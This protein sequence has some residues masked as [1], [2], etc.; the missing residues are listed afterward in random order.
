MPPLVDALARRHATCTNVP[1]LLLN[2]DGRLGSAPATRRRGRTS[3]TCPMPAR[4]LI[5]HYADALLHQLPQA[6]GADGDGPRL[7]V[8]VQL[9]L[10]LEVSRE[11]R[12]ARSRRSAW[13]E[14][15][16]ADR[17]AERLHHRR[18]LLDER[19]ARRGDGQA[20]QG[21]RA[22]EVLHRADAHRHHLQVPRTSIEMWKDCGKLADLPR[23]GVG[24]PTRGSRR[25][26]RRTRPT[27]TS[28][29]S[30][31]L[32]DLGVGFTPNFIVDPAWDRDD[33]DRLR[34]WIDETGAYNSGFSDPHAAAR[35]RP[36]GHG[37]ARTSTTHDWEMFDIVHAVLPT[38]LPLDEFYAEY[39][40]ALAARARRPL[41]ATR[42]SCK[43]YMQ[44][45]AG[46]GHA[47]R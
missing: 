16:R 25:S 23:P 34:D 3:T 40:G 41:P 6:A 22:S 39:S 44:L 9:L 38:K 11:R 20:D 45:G 32:K 4:H 17:G 7:P 14:E 26:T 28:R 5:E 24:R 15:L 43:T 2:R 13:C 1:G 37:Q 10:G 35:H 30:S 42:A 8:Q 12:S 36:L 29:P 21:R 19:E 27:T 33:F 46:A 47:A 31:I 18:H